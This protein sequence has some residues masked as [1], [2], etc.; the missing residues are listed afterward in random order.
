[1]CTISGSGGSILVWLK[2]IH[3]NWIQSASY[4]TCVSMF[5]RYWEYKYEWNTCKPGKFL[6]FVLMRNDS[7]AL[8]VWERSKFLI[9][10][11]MIHR[12]VV[13]YWE[14][15]LVAVSGHYIPSNLETMTL[16][17]YV[18]LSEVD[19][20]FRNSQVIMC[21]QSPILGLD[22]VFLLWRSWNA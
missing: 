20:C 14:Y 13:I 12:Q 21:L 11:G 8:R 19:R 15:W 9:I 7:V 22:W 16:N 10:K 2:K 18:I 3:F 1:M 17:F 6:K 5:T 4:S